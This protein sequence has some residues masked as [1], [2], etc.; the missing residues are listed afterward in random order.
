M[1]NIYVVNEGRQVETKKK[2]TFLSDLRISCHDE[3]TFFKQWIKYKKGDSPVFSPVFIETWIRPVLI[4]TMPQQN[5][6]ATK[7]SETKYH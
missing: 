2:K 7:N 1:S 4:K 6:T 5:K 3:D